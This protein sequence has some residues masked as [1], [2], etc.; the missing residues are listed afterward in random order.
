MSKRSIVHIEIPSNNTEE[1]AKFY[2]ELFDWD[3]DHTREPVSYTSFAAGN[4]GGGFP[5]VGEMYKPGDVLI[6]IASDDLEAD[7][8]KIESLGGTTLVPRMD[9]QG[10]GALA[11]FTD[12]T[13]NKVA[14]WKSNSQG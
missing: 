4:T 8:K 1:S 13:G 12:P 2:S 5:E 9:V 10:H 7:L 11:I 3:T 14:L 6:Y